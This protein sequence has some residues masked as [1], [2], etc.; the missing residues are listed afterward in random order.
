M[1]TFEIY[2][3]QIRLPGQVAGVI[4]QAE[5]APYEAMQQ[6]GRAFQQVGSALTNVSLDLWDKIK[7]ATTETE[8]ATAASQWTRD[9]A[10][11]MDEF[12]QKANEID[13]ETGKPRYLRA[14]QD[15]EEFAR[16]WKEQ[17]ANTFTYRDGEQAFWNSFQKTVAQQ[18]TQVSDEAQKIHIESLSTKAKRELQTKIQQ[19][20]WMGALEMTDLMV[21]NGL[22]T[23]GWGQIQKDDIVRAAAIRELRN[24]AF[25]LGWEEGEKHVLNA[26]NLT[27][28][29]WDG[30]LKTLT[31]AEQE[32][33]L[34]ELKEQKILA[35]KEYQTR[36]KEMLSTKQV[37]YLKRFDTLRESEVFGDTDLQSYLKD[38][39]VSEFITK[40]IDRIRKRN[41]DLEKTLK[42]DKSDPATLDWLRKTLEDM[43]AVGV[44]PDERRIVLSKFAEKLN[45]QDYSTLMQIASDDRPHQSV[46]YAKEVFDEYLKSINAKKTVLEPERSLQMWEQIR[47]DVRDRL[48]NPKGEFDYAKSLTNEEIQK[49]VKNRFDLALGKDFVKNSWY[50]SQR[51]TTLS[52]LDR[53]Q[54]GGLLGIVDA[55]ENQELFRKNQAYLL[56]DLQQVL[57]REVKDI[58]PS[59]ARGNR[60]YP[61][62]TIIFKTGKAG[63][64]QTWYMPQVEG[65]QIIW[66]RSE[67][68]PSKNRKSAW[69]RVEPAKKGTERNPT[70]HEPPSMTSEDLY[71]AWNLWGAP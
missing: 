35:E 27:Y 34:R 49:L 53:I 37:D 63:Q 25:S 4:R 1:G 30:S 23:E 12:R 36:I 9:A 62:G 11:W 17:N 20:D 5:T 69:T 38:R 15:F 48:V 68:E 52:Y 64:A 43:R 47:K 32:A 3:Q 44:P 67:V 28:R 14:T 21:R 51:A 60:E 55:P 59:Q 42:N 65:N 58:V 40:W 39:E 50:H 19:G 61:E 7:T 54:K 6:A 10:A 16:K 46:K 70:S 22:V 26:Q 57:G 45:G 33:I 8:I 2:R 71:K 13:P 29:N 56:D 31:P 41:E 18:I 24:Q 66:Y